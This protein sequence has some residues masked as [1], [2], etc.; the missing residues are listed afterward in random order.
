MNRFDDANGDAWF[1]VSAAQRSRWFLYRLDGAARGSHNNAFAVRLH[2]APD[3]AALSA[4]LQALVARHPLLRTRFRERDGEVEQAVAPAATLVLHVAPAADADLL[5][6]QLRADCMR[7]FDLAHAPLMRAH[8]YRCAPQES[9][10]LLAF[11]HL[12]GDGWSYWQLLGELGDTLNGTAP[13]AGA[14]AATYRDY[15]SWQNAWLASP[16]AERQARYWREQ[17]A[18]P[19]PVLQL[20]I[21]QPARAH[22]AHGPGHGVVSVQL[23]QALSAAL[24]ALA[25]QHASTLFSTLLAAYTVLLHRYSGQDDIIVGTPMHGRTDPAWDGVVGD[26]V[27]PVAIRTRFPEGVTLSQL[28]KSVRNSVLRGMHH[29]DF[30]FSLL[31]ERMAPLRPTRVADRAP[32]FQAMFVFQKAHQGANLMALWNAS[33]D[34]APLHW[35]TH[36]LGRYP[37][38]QSGGGA[39]LTLEAMETGAALR[40]DFRFDRAAFTQAAIADLA[41]N[42][43][44]L[45]QAMVDDPQQAA[46]RAPLLD[47]AQ[48]RRLL[49]GFND[50]VAAPTHDLLVHQLFEAQARRQPDAPALVHAGATLSYAW[51]NLRANGY[52]RSL[53]EMG[54]GPDQRV[55]LCATRGPAMVAAMLGILKAGGA[56]VPLDPAYPAER[57]AFMLADAA[58]A[59]LMTEPAMLAALGFAPDRTLLLDGPA[60]ERPGPHPDPHAPGL[61]PA[62]LAYVMYTSGSTGQPKGVMVEHGNVSN[63]V[64]WAMAS[65]TPGQLAAT[66]ATTSI[67]FDLSVFELFVPLCCGA[68]VRLERDVLAAPLAGVSL[69]NTVPSALQA[70]LDHQG[71][72]GSIGTVNT[73]GE[74]LKRSLAERVLEQPG[75]EQLC[76]LYGPTETTV[77]STWVRMGR[78][79]GFVP[80]IGRPIANTRIYLLDAH[81]EPV[82]HGV[83]G[84]IYIGG[85]G[86]ARG[87]LGRPALTAERFLTDPFSGAAQARMYKTG[88]LGRWLPDGN[89]MYLGRDDFQV[90]LRGF[91]I[92]LGEIEVALQAC[93][94]VREAA[95]LA[96]EDVPGAPHLV[97]Y[98]VMQAGHVATPSTLR[99]SLAARL[100]EFMVPAAFMTL[101]ALPLTAN[102]KLNRQALPAPDQAAL[103]RAAYQAP[104]GAHELAI[105]AI[106]QELLN[107]DAVGRDDHFFE[108]GGHS[109]MAV[110]V[111]ARLRQQLGLELAVGDLFAHPTLGAL[112]ALAARAGQAPGRI[113]H[114]GRAGPLPLSWAQQ[115]LWFLD[116]FDPAAS[117]AY[118]M[119]GGVRLHGALRPDVLQAAL[120]TI[121]ARH[122]SLRTRFAEIDGKPVQ[123]IDGARP[124]ALLRQDLRAHD[125]A[126]RDAALAQIGA[127]EASLPFDLGTGPLIRARLLRL[128]D[129]DHVL[130]LTQHHIVSDGWSIRV[131]IGELR[132]LYEAFGAGRAMPLPPLPIQ[133]PDF[134][135]W[136]RAWLQGPALQAQLTFWRQH[137]TGAPAL[138]ALPTDHARPP[139]QRHAGASVALSLAPALSAALRA[140]GQRHGATL[141][142]T[143]LAGWATLL[144]RLS[145]EHDVV[146]GTPFANRQHA[147]TETLIGFFVNTLALRVR[148]EDDPTV[149][150][151]LR[152][153]RSTTLQAQCNQ[154]LPFEQVVEALQPQRSLR[155]SPIFQVMLTL[156]NTPGD[157]VLALPGLTLTPFA[158]PPTHTQFDL[159]LALVEDGA[160]IAGTLVYAT[161]LFERASIERMLAQLTTLLG[162]MATGDQLQ[163][164]ELPLLDAAQRAHALSAY[165]FSDTGYPGEPLLHRLVEA[166]AAAHPHAVAVACAGRTLTYGQLNRQANRL[167]H[168]L[169]ARGARPDTLVALCLERSVD[170]V[171]AILGVLKAGAAYVPLDP[172][173]PP[174][175]LAHM[176]ADSAA[177]AVLTDRAAAP[178][179]AALAAAHAIPLLAVDLADQAADL[180]DTDPAPATGLCAQHLAYVI[181]TSG[182]T[183]MPKGVMVEHRNVVNL[184]SALRTSVYGNDDTPRNVAVNA[185]YAFDASVQGWTQLASGHCLFI[186]P[187]QLRADG[188]ALFAWLQANRIDVFDCVPSQLDMLVA[189]GLCGGADMYPRIVL[190][191][192]EAIGAAQW[193]T[194]AQAPH[195]VFHNVYGPTE[196]TVDATIARIDAAAP[197]P[198]L[199]RPLAN[200]RLYVLD[201]RG[202]PVPPGVT[203]E[204]HIGGAG[205]ARGYLN[206]PQLTAQRFIDDPFGHPGRLYRTGDLA[207]RHADGT[208]DYVGRNDF[209][210]KIR[211][212]RIE[213]GEIEACLL[214]CAGVRQAL[215]LAREDSPGDVRLVAYVV[216]D[217]G[218]TLHV[219]TVQAAVAAQL[220]AYMV[221]AAVVVLDQFPLTNTG[222]LDRAALPVPD[223]AALPGGVYAAPQDH[224]EAAVAALWQTLLNVPAVGRHDHFFALGGHSLL[225]VQLVARLRS[226]FGVEMPMRELFAWPVLADFAARVGLARQAA[227]DPI[228]PVARDTALPLSWAQQRLWMLDQLDAR[229]GA[230]YHMPA[231]F[232]IAGQLDRQVLQATLNRV[233]MR[234]EALRT[235]FGFADGQGVQTIGAADSGFQL[236]WHDL[237]QAD[238][239]AIEAVSTAFFGAGFDL[240]NGPLIRGCLLQR[241][242][243][244]HV[245]LIDQHHIVSDGWSIGVLMDEVSA[246]YTALR[247]GQPDPLAA[248]PIQYADYAAWQRRAQADRQ[249]Q[250][251]FWIS[252]LQGAPALLELPADRARPALQSHRGASIA[253]ELPAHLCSGL[254]SLGQRH[255]ATLFMTLLAGWSVL[256]AR[257]SG[258]DDIV[259]G[260]PTANR[261]RRELE[262]LIGFFANTLAL[263]T[264]LHD[265]PSVAQ[266]L[267]RVKQTTLDAFAHQ[268][269]PFEQVVEALKPTR[270]LSHSPLFQSM[271][272]LDNTPAGRLTLPGLRIDRLP[273]HNPAAHF[274]VSLALAESGMVL[275]GE[276][277]FACAL[278]DHATIARLAGHF[279]QLLAS[280]VAD[281]QQA[282]SR[283]N[284]LTPDERRQLLHDFNDTAAAYPD[285]ALIHQC[286]EAQAQACADAT[287]VVFQGERFSY[288]QLNAR[289]NQVAHHLLALGV[290]PDDRIAICMQRGPTMIIALLGILKAGAAYLPLDLSYPR[291][292]LDYMLG[293]SAPRALLTESAQL[294]QLPPWELPL[295]VVDS[296]PGLAAQ[297]QT[298]IDPGLLGLHAGHLAYVIYTSGSTGQ[299]KGVMT[300]HRNVVQLVID[301]PCI[302][303]RADDC[304][305]FCANPAFDASTWEIWGG[306]L[307][308]A[309]VLIVT[310]ATLLDPAALCAALVAE[311]VSILHLTMGLFNQYA[312][313]L[314]AC[315]A[316]LRYLL[317]G[318]DHADLG[319]VTRV[320]HQCRPQHLLHAYGPTETTTF[321]ST[322]EITSLEPGSSVL[323]VGRPIANT[324]IYLL[325]RHGVPVPLG[326]TGEIYIGGAGVARGYLN[327]P[328]QSAQHFLHDPFDSAPQ[329]RMYRT[330]D[331]ARFFPDGNLH[332]L[333][334]NDLQVKVRGFRIELGEI[335]TRLR[336]CGGVR[337][338]VVMARGDDAGG[339]RLVAYLTA[340]PGWTLE[341]AGL[342]AELLSALPEYMVPGA[343]VMLDQFAVTAN[344]KLDRAS[345]PAPTLATLVTAP[346]QAAQ[347]ELEEAIAQAWQ[348]LLG[349]ARVG[350]NDHFFELGGHS[351]LAVQLVSQLRQLH[352]IEVP[353]SDLFEH[354]TLAG[355]AQRARLAG[356]SAVQ[357][358]PAADRTA[359]LPLSWAQ[360]RLWFLDQLDSAASAAYHLPASERLDG[361]LDV[362]ALQ[363]A[364]DCIVARHDILRTRFVSVQGHT[365][366]QIDPPGRGFSLQRHDLR[367]TSGHEQAYA[368]ARIG[369][370]FFEAGFDLAAGPLIR[371]CLLQTGAER[372]IL[373]I[374]QHHI[375]TDAASVGILMREA[376]T[377]YAAFSS[378]RPN[379]LAA[380]KV[381]YADYAAWQ[382]NWLQGDVLQTQVAFWKSHLAGAP[383]LLALPLDHARPARQSY[384]G[385]SMALTLPPALSA[386]LHALSARHGTTLF[387]TLMAAWAV[388]MA[389]ISGQDD[390][391]IGTPV[392]TRRRSEWEDL[393][394]FFVN[395]MALRTRL[396]DDPTVAALL[397]RVKAAMLATFA[398]QEIPF[399]Q[400]VEA[401]NPV[402]S[403]GHSA[404]FQS[405][406]AFNTVQAGGG[407]QLPGLRISHLE[408]AYHTTQFDLAMYMQDSD[409]IVSGHLNFA[410]SLF[411]PASIARLLGHFVALLDSMVADDQQRVSALNLLSAEQRAHL[412]HALN[413]TARAYPDTLLVHQMFEQRAAS[414]PHAPAV[415]GA[416]RTMTYDE[417][418]NRA[419][420][421]AQR[422]LAMGAG[423]DRRIAI[424]LERSAE[425]VIA[426]LA[427]LKAGSAYVPLDPSSPPE[428]L[429]YMLADSAPLA[430]L[431]SAGARACLPAQ[432]APL[433][434]VD[435]ASVAEVQMAHPNPQPATLGLEARHLAYLI[436]T[437]G[438]TGM[439]KGVMV[440]HGGLRN[441]LQWALAHYAGAAPRDAV[442]SSPFA[443]DAT[444]TSIYV[445]LLSGGSATLIADG[446]EL[447][448]LE[449]LLLD[450]HATLLVKITPAHLT[451]LG[452]HLRDAG[453]TCPAH[454]FVIGGEALP[455]ATVALW[456]ALSPQSRLV[457]EYGPTETV[458]GCTVYAAE[459]H[460]GADDV[461]IGRPI[462]NTRIHVLD[463]HRQ[464]VPLGVVGEIHIGGAGVAR[465]YL[466]RPDLT[467][468]RFIADP[469][470]SVPG[471]R[472]YKTGDLGRWLADGNLQYLGRND[473]QVK[474][475]GYRIELGEIEARLLACDGVREAVVVARAEGAGDKRLVAYIVAADGA[476]PGA[477]ALRAALASQLAEYM[478]PSAFVT[479]ERLPL[480][481][482][483]KLDRNA[484]P[485]PDA[486]AHASG[487]WEAP[488]DT[489]EAGIAGIWQSLLGIERVGRN[490]HFFELGG[491][492]LLV[493]QLIAQVRE[494]FQIELSLKDVFEQPTVRQLAAVA[495]SQQLTHYLEDDMTMLDQE[496]DQ[497]SESELRAILAGGR[498]D[499]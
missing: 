467:A 318:G 307:N 74:P 6:R 462:A 206:A 370:G 426:L 326:V 135:V 287:A 302:A 252:H 273:H 470:S 167:A 379:P 89:L 57:L 235:T 200:T 395:T 232:A 245:L 231:R 127:A 14:P 338:A 221:P 149:A 5:D 472:L 174:G 46:S 293:D 162:A 378:G 52:A 440:E 218:A 458:V 20:P 297:P 69:V 257:M 12:V 75:V 105:A 355:F 310:Q 361:V 487:T 8:L 427:V 145:G 368:I 45:L 22:A 185:S 264:R 344:G 169:L 266:L 67:N 456:Q 133:Y 408:Q 374:D 182:S 433:L 199:G 116:R 92:E 234:H 164:S 213:A 49:E 160:G 225:A 204:L 175:R 267:E 480:T 256:M 362:E 111:V 348:R 353:V 189:A 90:K 268:E 21:E 181:Y 358:I 108:L 121:V 303:F 117:A 113:V 465:G 284:L 53:L 263:R 155:H 327:R 422:L 150:Q 210:F 449:P 276:I 39:A 84:E 364:L 329:A 401:L 147:D 80:H 482:N 320:F 411:E 144:S 392:S 7:P 481:A 27:N 495:T 36:R 203:G 246:L 486:H 430:L 16:D 337:E 106:W 146:I 319:A 473:F 466:N 173:A 261:Q 431:T 488:Q 404:V 120:E 166:R 241:G 405:V 24:H 372:H 434:V 140:L 444:I 420:A 312:D 415:I 72:A 192:G 66:L 474:L 11:D 238:A 438:S 340:L 332:F 18:A 35:G 369:A 471:A 190:V 115:R 308:G 142:M 418:N 389:R 91:R 363:A 97:A 191:G 396:H 148:C 76:N 86:V 254:R 102:G 345:L 227:Q 177:L 479:L 83:T 402:R 301:E 101:E 77:Y 9:V 343:F 25:R 300:T 416:G 60:D 68:T 384:R 347:G 197:R 455:A 156:D 187:Q 87:Y 179:L 229:A 85:A 242:D 42:F 224:V 104:Q 298:N 294:A 289:A 152:Q 428:R 100:P 29:Q 47:A 439:P 262:H 54:I 412:V 59:V 51:L 3:V 285:Q 48:R 130:L 137:L 460:G 134:A 96:R 94:G 443:F 81:G 73:C 136:Q 400:V 64:D 171:V 280:M 299:P 253:I 409:G 492:S 223:R 339:K 55:A 139:Q 207:R 322:Y 178:Q 461:P 419:N 275:R 436:Y 110:R 365:T 469:L 382:R 406:L 19:L 124:F 478:L 50:S 188:A 216:A 222:K 296:D 407:L 397:A 17:L 325:D 429:A 58:P 30:P 43:Q 334:R 151:L 168:C 2:G 342:R 498:D 236:A 313:T 158:S 403:M 153:V 413:D 119:A 291:E 193:R 107:L 484:L 23:P 366:Q 143:L 394:G 454:L 209:Q 281:D 172:Q 184:W 214:A 309:R 251:A 399:E 271:L 33:D 468:E 255:G 215:V 128:A 316:R 165:N 183:G 32:V 292:R 448:R 220:P 357:A 239:A 453:R 4:A 99:T 201:R 282:V 243:D 125:R 247:A 131:L 324:R 445:P 304:T 154:D 490:D 497:L 249:D 485:A 421:L 476:S 335:E 248:P 109:L 288:A 373:L 441:Y 459:H 270:S 61:R 499:A 290:R 381:Q 95:V 244:E 346:W 410:L 489:L 194:L 383:E 463:A 41:H 279:Q 40:C 212:H 161:D 196:C 56:Y 272:V 477:G 70:L 205:V 356:S 44:T 82:P 351:L 278:F 163:L 286:F 295:L 323:P 180:A 170:M 250:L 233:V 425:M 34:G 330:G 237:R 274:D 386:G 112:G 305:A 457:N 260:T 13:A 388:L 195:T 359:A 217:A 277:E 352:G 230:A 208:L 437:S 398:H 132:M 198:H 435:S 446:E 336:L 37:L 390:I 387:V 186:V 62:H 491:H 424:C 331:L 341:P 1:P 38:H 93:A 354:P 376:S 493:V 65:F 349:V 10:L 311:G 202:E 118:H 114:A 138:L 269:T 28:L 360:Q 265:D 494:Q 333:G 385:D 447:L 15:V 328:E 442:V 350:R 63:F 88:D 129:D 314:A 123:V 375:I 432:T 306:L 122:E 258:Q 321:T 159:S 391:V 103:A 240:A 417:L 98:L 450:T 317:I 283:L 259:I 393:I 71:L 464:L 367:Q 496:I 451:A 483:G 475:R 377:L 79:G 176:L 226:E 78:K 452:Q 371:G 228:G 211:G 126:Q 380:L 141:F 219:D 157:A 315:F 26:F 414:T 31:V 423:P